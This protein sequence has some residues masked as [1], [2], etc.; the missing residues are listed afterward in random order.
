[1]F[2]GTENI[3]ASLY[4]GAP[5]SVFRYYYDTLTRFDVNARLGGIAMPVL[6]IHGQNDCVIDE[7]TFDQLRHILS[8]AEMVVK[9][10]GHFIPPTS[11]RLFNEQLLRFLNGKLI[12]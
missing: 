7:A 2:D 1:M 10:H 12:D 4:A 3:V 11:S 8:A 9:G 6:L 5:M